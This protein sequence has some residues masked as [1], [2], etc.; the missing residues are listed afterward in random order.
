MKY[1]DE[2]PADKIADMVKDLPP[3]EILAAIK[4]KAT[5]C[6]KF[7][8]LVKRSNKKFD[9][10]QCLLDN[11]AI[12]S[13]INV[14]EDR[15]IQVDEDVMIFFMYEWVKRDK[16]LHELTSLFQQEIDVN[17]SLYAKII[18]LYICAAHERNIGSGRHSERM[19]QAQEAVAE[20]FNKRVKA[21]ENQSQNPIENFNF[22]IPKAHVLPPCRNSYNDNVRKCSFCEAVVWS[23][24]V[25]DEDETYHWENH[26]WCRRLEAA[27]LY[28][29]RLFPDLNLSA[30]DWSL[31]ELT[32]KLDLRTYEKYSK[33]HKLNREIFTRF[34]G[35]LNRL[36]ELR[37]RIKCRECGQYMR[38]D[39]DKSKWLVVKNIKDIANVDHFPVLIATFKCQNNDCPEK[40]KEVYLSYCWHCGETIDSRDSKVKIAGKGSGYYLCNNCGAGYKDYID[41]H[42]EKKD[43]VKYAIYP[44]TICPSCTKCP[45]CGGQNFDLK[46]TADGQ[47]NLV[48]KCGQSMTVRDTLQDITPKKASKY[49]KYECSICKHKLEINHERLN[50]QLGDTYVPVILA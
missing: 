30:K 37:E 49:K 24:K 13:E 23:K 50:K 7:P 10:A 9:W 27:D 45:K 48:C 28:C 2:L 18:Y 42:G 11:V 19:N 39:L 43:G 22:D 8:K 46:E 44:G 33:D 15:K 47:F 29:S 4:D 34:G 26:S 41:P 32:D 35:E 36:N 12:F 31:I 6:E 3:D 14:G 16:P 17:A 25:F 1:F 5:F 38:A 40:G 20:I 21:L